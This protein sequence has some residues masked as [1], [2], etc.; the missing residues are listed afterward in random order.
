MA[1]F[2]IKVVV[3]FKIKVVVPFRVEMVVL[4]E[5]KMEISFKIGVG[6][7]IQNRSAGSYHKR[8][9][10]PFRIRMV[11]IKKTGRT[12]MARTLWWWEYF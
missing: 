2:K 10:I 9:V 8:I 12:S 7:L 5:V 11:E 1:P 3:P 4:L 6:G